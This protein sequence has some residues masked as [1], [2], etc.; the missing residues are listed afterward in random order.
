MR[1]QVT[2][3]TREQKQQAAIEYEVT[4]SFTKTSKALSIP[5]QTIHNW[6]KEE[7]WVELTSQV[8][9][10]K[11]KQHRAKYSHILDLAQDRMV[12][13][14]PN[15]TAQQASVI[16]GI[17]FDKL[18]LI[19]NLATSISGKAE[20]MSSLAQEFRKISAQWDSLKVV[21]TQDKDE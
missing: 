7:W 8:R 10:E 20:S 9:T 4:G 3:W 18:R 19:D 5:K 2:V 1:K 14:L 11:T 17:A 6:S 21:A 13:D 12:E 15:A 16:G